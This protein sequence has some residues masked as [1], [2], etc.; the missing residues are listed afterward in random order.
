VDARLP[1]ARARLMQYVADGGTLVVQYNTNNFL[2]KVPTEIG[3]KPFRI[4]QQRVTDETA[5]VEFVDPAHPI[6][7]RPNRIGAREFAGWVQERGL[8]FA[9][10]WDGAYQPILSLHDP[11]ESP[12][13]GGLL[14]AHHGKGAFIYTGLAFFR[15][16]PAGVPGAYRLF[17]NLIEHGPAG[18]R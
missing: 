14:V 11:G 6:L 18:A 12:Q 5:A 2:S 15:Q 10:Q 3:P 17:A 16:L 9:D 13:K 4:S 7:T 1:F 8:S